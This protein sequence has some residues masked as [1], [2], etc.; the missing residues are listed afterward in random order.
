MTSIKDLLANAGGITAAFDKHSQIGAAVQGTVT[1]A[2][3]RQ[4]TDFDSGKPETWDDGTPKQQLRIVIQTDQRTSPD[5]DG[6][7]AV[8]IKWWGEQR[9]VMLK[10]MDKAGADD[11][12]VG[13]QFWAR[14]AGSKPNEKNP[15]LADIKIYEYAYQ[16]PANTAGLNMDPSQ[17]P[18]QPAQQQAPAF[19]QPVQ[20]QQ[21][22]P[23]GGGWNAP[24]NDPWTAGQAP[25]QQAQ[26]MQPY[27][28]QP[29]PAFGQAQAQAAQQA[30]TQH[31][32]AQPVQQQQQAPAPAAPAAPP[33]PPAGVD[34]AR[35]QQFLQMGLSDAEVSG[36]TG[37]P[38]EHVAAIRA[39]G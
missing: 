3:V 17:Q 11:V 20:Q 31:L 33:A 13:G 27:I 7:R 9:Q 38:V 1:D 15:R 26:P 25:Q 37:T 39:A 22:M 19:Q 30:V 18:G 4:T 16:K 2:D 34:V 32:D 14:Y 12:E 8:Y 29:D 23:Q 36:A 10:A 5:D 6:K 35:V 24:V 28:Q 21:Q